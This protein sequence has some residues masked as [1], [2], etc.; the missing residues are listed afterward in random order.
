MYGSGCSG[1][2]DGVINVWRIEDGASLSRCMNML[3]HTSVTELVR[4]HPVIAIRL[5]TDHIPNA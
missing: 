4:A 5:Q 3:P 2:R 1:G